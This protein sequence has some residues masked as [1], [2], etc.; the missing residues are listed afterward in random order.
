MNYCFMKLRFILSAGLVL[1]LSGLTVQFAEAQADSPRAGD[2]WDFQITPY[3]WGA[4]VDG[5]VNFSGS[6]PI[7]RLEVDASRSFNDTLNSLDLGAMSF[8]EGRSDRFGVFGEFFYIRTTDSLSASALVPPAST[9]VTVGADLRNTFTTALAAGQFHA[10]DTG[11]TSVDLL[12]G[13]RYWSLDSRAR[14]TESVGSQSA[15]IRKD[16]SAQWG[17]LIFGAKARHA[18]TSNAY[19]TGWAMAGGLGKSDYN[20]WDLM[21]AFGYSFSPRTSLL[22]GYRYLSLEY[23]R[24]R[25]EFDADLHG[26]GVGLN[27]RF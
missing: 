25:F 18:I 27:F 10:M 5:S 17:S 26:P 11:K 13:L 4:G 24:S 21:A 16:E 6:G 9:P 7:P 23:T 22:A 19:I 15:G 2:G 3:I 14:I 1:G 12:L 20:S 8:F